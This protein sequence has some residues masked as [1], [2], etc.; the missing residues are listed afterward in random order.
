MEFSGADPGFWKGGGGGGGQDGAR[1]RMGRGSGWGGGQDVGP[2]INRSSFWSSGG[3]RKWATSACKQSRWLFEI[4]AVADSEGGVRGV[5][6]PFRG[7]C[8]CF[9]LVSIWK[10][11][12]TWTLT[13]PLKEFL[14]PPLKRIYNMLS[15]MVALF[16]KI[17]LTPGTRFSWRL[18][19]PHPPAPPIPRRV[20]INF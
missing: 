10:F 20:L 2:R 5:K 9:L 1:V 15:S 4:K 8:F 18:A 7:C 17:W 16:H 14:D 13:P 6:P 11:P 19:T 12:R 3:V